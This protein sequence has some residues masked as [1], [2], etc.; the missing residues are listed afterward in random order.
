M[1]RVVRSPKSRFTLTRSACM[2]VGSAL[3]RLV[4]SE[5]S[6]RPEHELSQSSAG[7]P[8]PDREPR[9]TVSV[10]AQEA[11]TSFYALFPTDCIVADC[12]T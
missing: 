3:V 10:I 1:E 6:I 7:G 2:P 8:V 4:A 11:R 12:Q 5:C 9:Y